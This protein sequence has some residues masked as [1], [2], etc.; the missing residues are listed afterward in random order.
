MAGKV[1]KETRIE[2]VGPL[3]PIIAESA[4]KVYPYY[5]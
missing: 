5:G 1:E 2:E 3:M 4:S